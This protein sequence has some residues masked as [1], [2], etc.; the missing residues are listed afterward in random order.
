[1]IA[2]V[3]RL[4]VGG[5]CLLVSCAACGFKGP[6]YLPVHRAAVVTHP[7]PASAEKSKLRDAAQP[8]RKHPDEGAASPPGA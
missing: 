2:R 3:T 7:A 4:V 6:L 8:A 5:A 1:M